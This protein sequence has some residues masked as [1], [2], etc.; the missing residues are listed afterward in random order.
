MRGENTFSD[1][2][3]FFLIFDLPEH[4]L[5]GGWPSWRAL[6]WSRR[7]GSGTFR[8]LSRAR[9]A[10]RSWRSS[11]YD[12]ASSCPRCRL[13]PPRSLRRV[14]RR[15]R[16]RWSCSCSHLE[17]A[18]EREG[19]SEWASE[20]VGQ[21]SSETVVTGNRSGNGD[22]FIRS[23]RRYYPHYTRIIV[24]IRSAATR[25]ATQNCM[26]TCAKCVRVC[27]LYVVCVWF[28]SRIKTSF[29]PGHFFAIRDRAGAKCDALCFV[30]WKKTTRI[31]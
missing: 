11:G 30:E 18:T 1:S 13:C 27:G 4:V 17:A 6:P 16:R 12:D 19:Q 21:V 8:T 23:R 9:V 24:A 2:F 5:P 26:R 10:D 7:P 31:N 15:C 20:R 14:P 25:V 28:R 3:F 29:A 22:R